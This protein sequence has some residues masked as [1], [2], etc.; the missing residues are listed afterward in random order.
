MTVAI[1]DLVAVQCPACAVEYAIPERLER[2]AQDHRGPAGHSIYC[3]N[4]HSW[5]YLGETDAERFERLYRAERDRAAA[6][7]AERDQL[8]ASLR[9]TRGV[10]TK[11]R[12]RATAGTCPFGCRRHFVNLERHV[13][14]RHP[15]KLLEGE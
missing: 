15:G 3:P 9:S 7:A 8:T 2:T 1:R 4:G 11:L 6:I 5:H 10:V 12:K 14:N 13:A